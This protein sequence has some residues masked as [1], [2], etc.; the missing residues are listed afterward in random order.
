MKTVLFDF[1]GTI[2]D[3]LPL[4]YSAFRST[5][6]QFL[7]KHYA[8]SDIRKLMGPAEIPIIESLISADQQETAIE[9]FYQTYEDE[10]RSIHNHPEIIRMLDTFQAHNIKMGL[11]TAKG[12]RSADISIHALGLARY[13]NPV[14]CGDEVSKGKPD[15]EGIYQAMEQL[16]AKPDTTLFVG[17]GNADIGAARAAGITAVGV[18][19]LNDLHPTKVLQPEP[20]YFFRDISQFT[21]W[22]IDR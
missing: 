8:D 13:F 19:W 21:R 7:G 6:Q 9:Y 17:D 20:D 1:D 14:I 16:A 11:V 18:N 12:R 5:F 10:H 2:A 15:P 22:V 4:I 3:T